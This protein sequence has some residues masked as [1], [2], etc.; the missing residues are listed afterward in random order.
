MKNDSNF[1]VGALTTTATKTILLSTVKFD[2]R[3][4]RKARQHAEVLL[5]QQTFRMNN[6]KSKKKNSLFFLHFVF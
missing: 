3:V 1:Q 4:E 5:S 2:D 6:L